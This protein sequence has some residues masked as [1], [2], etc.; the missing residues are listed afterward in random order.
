MEV[1]N[2][3]MVRMVW[4]LPK[5][6]M[7]R[8]IPR[9]FSSGDRK[10]RY[11]SMSADVDVTQEEMEAFRLKRDRAGDPMAKVMDQGDS[12]EEVLLEYKK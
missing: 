9:M 12:N 5:T 8:I 7:I 6:L 4:R 11:N 1:R 3:W 2:I 10:R